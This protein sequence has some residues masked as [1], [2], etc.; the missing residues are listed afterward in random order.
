MG[1]GPVPG[2]WLAKRVGPIA[3]FV[4]SSVETV[5]KIAGVDQVAG[6]VLTQELDHVRGDPQFAD[7]RTAPNGKFDEAGRLRVFHQFGDNCVVFRFTSPLAEFLDYF[8]NVWERILARVALRL[9]RHDAQSY[10]TPGTSG[11]N[12]KAPDEAELGDT[13]S[14]GRCLW[15]NP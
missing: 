9:F 8:A 5:L 11:V 1:R 3:S 10:Q 14:R 6:V 7:L 2:F 12:W 4:F 15:T 13:A